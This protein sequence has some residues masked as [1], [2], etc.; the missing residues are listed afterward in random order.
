LVSVVGNIGAG[1]STALK[2]FQRDLDGQPNSWNRTVCVCEPVEKWAPLLRA[3]TR[4]ELAWLE[5]QVTVAAFY[6]SLSDVI[7][8]TADVAVCER[9]LMSVALF[10]GNNRA[11]A[12]LLLVLADSRRVM[13]PEV[14]VHL[15]TPWEVCLSRVETAK[16]AQA[17]DKYAANKGAE[18]F[19]AL[20]CRHQALMKWYA[21]QGCHIIT[22]QDPTLTTEGLAE[23]R[24]C[25]LDMRA[26]TR[27]RPV[28]K[29][30]M[31]GLLHVLWPPQE[32]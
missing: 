12:S 24:S 31:A 20:H 15:N 6:A 8:P 27:Q 7:D 21:V 2:A 32:F 25:A 16:R 5:L 18:Y 4:S 3:M 13:L 22:V 10:S 11:I 19:H 26:Q 14:V 28:T 23:A 17:G 1:K 30:M 9:D 29:A